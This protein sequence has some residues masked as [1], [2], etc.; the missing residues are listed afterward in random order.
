MME[1]SGTPTGNEIISTD[2]EGRMLTIN[3]P[4]SGKVKLFKVRSISVSTI[5]LIM[6]GMRS[7]IEL[8]RRSIL[9]Q[10]LPLN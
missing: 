5:L 9:R 6:R 7:R 2:F 8:W 4:S 10:L 3:E 1:V